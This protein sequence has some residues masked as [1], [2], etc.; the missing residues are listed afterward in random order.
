[1][2]SVR[3]VTDRLLAEG[4]REPARPLAPRLTR[5]AVLALTVGAGV[6]GLSACAPARDRMRPLPADQIVFAVASPPAVAPPVEW[7]LQSPSL[8]VYGSGRVLRALTSAGRHT[9][10]SAYSVAQVEA[11]QVARFV[12]TVGRSG[13]LDSDFG[14]PRV[15]D[16]RS[17]RVWLHGADGEQRASA[18]GLDHD[19]DSYVSWVYR[20]RRRRLRSLIDNGFALAGDTGT[21]YEP[22][23]VFVIEPAV[24]RDTS[25]ATVRWPGPDPV[26]FLH[27]PGPRSPSVQACGE[28]D[29]PAAGELYAA[30][31]S[32]EDQRW[33]LGGRTR[34]LVVNPFPIDLDC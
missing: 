27:A 24:H 29:G 20:L 11:Q 13:L 26:S 22:E 30:A 16:L 6:G 33:L 23:R 21:P 4:A 19:N 18:Y 34:A 9:V 31:R 15:S 10:P 12:A 28:L 5:R 32:S 1:M 8:I 3:R 25:E 7:A 17:T 14:E 2:A